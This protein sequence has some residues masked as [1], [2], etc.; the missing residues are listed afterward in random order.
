MQGVRACQPHLG[1]AGW[2]LEAQNDLEAPFFD[3]DFL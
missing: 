2:N 1:E 3:F